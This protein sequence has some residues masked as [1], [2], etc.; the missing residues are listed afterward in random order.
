MI[1]AFACC[2][3]GQEVPKSVASMIINS[4]A[5][6]IW[7]EA[8]LECKSLASIALPNGV[9]KIGNKAFHKCLSLLTS[10]KIPNSVSATIGSND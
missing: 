7:H 9:T 6:E 4:L 10:I 2:D 1:V 3:N 5:T 8:F